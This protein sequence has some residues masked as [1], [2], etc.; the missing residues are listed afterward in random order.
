[1]FNFSGRTTVTAYPRLACILA[2]VVPG[3]TIL[4]WQFDVICYRTS[5]PRQDFRLILVTGLALV[6]DEGQ[7]AVLRDVVVVA[8]R[9][10]FARCKSPSR[11][12][13]SPCLPIDITVPKVVTSSVIYKRYNIWL[14]F[15]PGY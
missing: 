7:T 9:A 3:S 12:S 14:L 5:F 11:H 15:L 10:H 6:D 1:M 4:L 13:T 8:S 2:F